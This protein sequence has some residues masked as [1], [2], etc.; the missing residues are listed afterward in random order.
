MTFRLIPA[1]LAFSSC[2]TAAD[3]PRLA[4]PQA[5][6][7]ET[8]TLDQ[9]VRGT[10]R[11]VLLHELG[12]GLV[13]LYSLPVLGREEDA[14]DRFAAWWLSPDGRE[15]G[16]DA[17]AAIE[18]WMASAKQSHARREELP[19]WDEHG[20]DEQRGYQIA[21][22]LYGADPQTMGPLAVRL[23]LP[24]E[25]QQSCLGEAAQNATSW[26]VHLI[27]KAA[28]M[29]H[30]LDGFLVPVQLLPAP[31]ALETAAQRVSELGL[32]NELRD[33]LHQFQF[34]EGDTMVRLVA[35][36]CGQANAFWSPDERAVV[37]CYELVE[38][39][40]AVGLEAGFR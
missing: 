13:D 14:A 2:A 10:L 20:I 24:E 38:H 34:P 36:E 21:C 35:Q 6:F 37:L 15:T 32:M 40:Q 28:Q 11:F 31:P 3:L 5:M 30:Q 19:W 8:I 12:H 33:L 23:G 39:V 16:V 27:G 26:S 9:F 4:P 7:K 25:R 22:L 1:I 18:W 17:I 29:P